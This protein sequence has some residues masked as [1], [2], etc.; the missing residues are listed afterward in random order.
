MGDSRNST[1]SKRGDTEQSPPRH[2]MHHT[3]LVIALR[4]LCLKRL[5]PERAPRGQALNDLRS[6]ESGLAERVM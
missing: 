6:W 1:E 2:C 3:L 5:G 4:A